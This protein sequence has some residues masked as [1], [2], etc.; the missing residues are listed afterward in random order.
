MTTTMIAKRQRWF[1][2]RSGAPDSRSLAHPEE[3]DRG[4]APG[5][6]PAEE[7]PDVPQ[8]VAGALDEEDRP[9]LLVPDLVLLV[10]GED[11]LAHEESVAV[12]DST[13]PRS[14]ALRAELQ[15]A[16]T[17][18][19]GRE[20]APPGRRAPAA[21]S[22]QA[23]LRLRGPQWR[24]RIS[25]IS[26]GPAGPDH[27]WGNRTVRGI[28]FPGFPRGS[29]PKREIARGGKLGIPFKPERGGAV[30]RLL[31]L[32]TPPGACRCITHDR[33]GRVP[34]RGKLRP[35]LG[36]LP[37]PRLR[38]RSKRR[39]RTK[40]FGSSG[41]SRAEITACRFRPRPESTSTS[42][43]WS[44]RDRRRLPRKRDRSPGFS[45]TFA[46]S[47]NRGT[48]PGCALVSPPRSPC[49]VSIGGTGSE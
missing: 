37:D 32:S 18:A 13:P 29:R 12:E 43:S 17:R 22:R 19:A 38:V 20:T 2:S 35:P 14:R 30:F 45:R 26:P 25:C 46:F 21:V 36:R 15:R 39:G 9:A 24:H 5:E 41:I 33:R 6:N 7:C 3:R 11:P 31:L 27:T 49:T 8:V 34:G 40:G 23:R 42:S 4:E 28:D 16:T 1:R 48:S 44:R 10:N 47:P